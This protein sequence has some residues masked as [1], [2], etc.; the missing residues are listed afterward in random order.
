MIK[1]GR[2]LLATSKCWFAVL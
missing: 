1:V 2:R